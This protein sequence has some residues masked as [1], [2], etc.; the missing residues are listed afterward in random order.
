[1]PTLNKAGLGEHFRIKRGV[2]QDCVLSRSLFNFYA[3]H[4]FRIA[5]INSKGI[6]IGGQWINNLED[7]DG[8]VVLA[9]SEE[10]FQEIISKINEVG[11]SYNMKINEK[12]TKPMVTNKR[13]EPT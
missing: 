6:H 9:E 1:M 13:G 2:R 7:A 4:I 3:E 10:D 11:K 12:M 5:C 8:T